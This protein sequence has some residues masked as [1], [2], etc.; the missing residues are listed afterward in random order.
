MTNVRRFMRTTLLGGVI[1]LIP[2]VAVVAVLG[3]AV[4]IM[5]AVGIPL[6]EMIPVASVAGI[7]IVPILTTLIL[8]LPV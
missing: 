6:G 8:F 3:K 5:Q 2:L 1:F 4:S 7:A